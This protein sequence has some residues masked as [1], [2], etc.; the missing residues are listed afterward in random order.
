MEI[1]YLLNLVDPLQ[2]TKFV[3]YQIQLWLE[4]LKDVLGRVIR[5]KVVM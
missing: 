1:W 2:T 3:L 4:A 5:P